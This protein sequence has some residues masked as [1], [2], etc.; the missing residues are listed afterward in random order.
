M[1][2]KFEYIL[3]SHSWYS[4]IVLTRLGRM[5]GEQENMMHAHTTVASREVL[6][7]SI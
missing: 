3:L 5:D 7:Y 2:A 4:D 6:N 1:Y